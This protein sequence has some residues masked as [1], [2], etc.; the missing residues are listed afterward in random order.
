[1][2]II[3]QKVDSKRLDRK[4][5]NNNNLEKE[6]DDLDAKNKDYQTELSKTHLFNYIDL[7]DY[8]ICFTYE[9]TLQE[10]NYLK[11]SCQIGILT[12]KWPKL[13][14]EELTQIMERLQK[15]WLDGRYFIRFDSASPKDG[16]GNFPITN[17]KDLIMLLITSQRSLASLSSGYRKLYFMEFN[18]EFDSKKEV[19]VF[20]KDNKVTCISQYHWDEPCYFS[21][22]NDDQL[23]ILAK[24][25][26]NEVELNLIPLITNKI[27]INNFTVDYLVKEDLTLKI[28][29]LNSFGYWLAAG[30]CLFNWIIDRNILYDKMNEQ[31]VYFRI[32]V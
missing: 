29:E 22:L 2:S 32:S 10:S 6:P 24:N 9:F 18:P 21:K 16:E 1:M 20:V 4:S 13:Y 25:I 27:N 19:R 28:I 11:Q 3:I 8:Q 17:P 31:N 15:H 12:G 30:S 14:D 5:V 23:M 7:F 26:I